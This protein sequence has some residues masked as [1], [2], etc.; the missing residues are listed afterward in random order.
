[1][2]RCPLMRRVLGLAR[3]T[4]RRRGANAPRELLLALGLLSFSASSCCCLSS[5]S[6]SCHR[7]SSSSPFSSA[8][9]SQSQA[10]T[11]HQ[12][13]H[14][15][16]APLLWSE[17]RGESRSRPRL[18]LYFPVV[19]VITISII[20]LGLFCLLC[21]LLPSVPPLLVAASPRMRLTVNSFNS[22]LTSSSPGVLVSS[23]NS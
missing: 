14:S 8:L 12:G 4:M 17:I 21:I 22:S 5:S 3:P 9:F 11:L 19:L 13:R 15:Q 2:A 20:A 16:R 6:L 23:P 1:M 7:P 18:R 10:V